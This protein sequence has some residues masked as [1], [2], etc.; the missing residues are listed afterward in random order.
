MQIG[1]DRSAPC[2]SHSVFMLTAEEPEGKLL[3]PSLE[4]PP[5]VTAPRSSR[6]QAQRQWGILPL[7]A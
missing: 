1:E 3:Q 4:G 7:V 5:A 2:V 6:G